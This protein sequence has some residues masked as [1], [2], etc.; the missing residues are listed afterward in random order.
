MIPVKDLIK[1]DDVFGFDA[2]TRNI[3]AVA[4]AEEECDSDDRIPLFVA[5]GKSPQ[6]ATRKEANEGEKG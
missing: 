6:K 3:E 1:E 4:N 5:P 2:P